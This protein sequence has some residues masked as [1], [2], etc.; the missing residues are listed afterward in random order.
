M[1]KFMAIILILAFA[2]VPAAVFADAMQFQTN[3]G[4]NQFLYRCGDAVCGAPGNMLSSNLTATA[5]LTPTSCGAVVGVGTDS[6]TFTLPTGPTA[7]QP[8][9]IIQ[10][11]N[12][13]T[14]GNNIIRIASNGSSVFAGTCFSGAAIAGT[15]ISSAVG[16]TLTNTKAT[17]KTGDTVTLVSAGTTTWLVTNC[18]GTW[19]S[20]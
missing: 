3:S 9:C 16:S 11:A 10:F 2:L 14:A 19:A 5:T 4:Q 18:T 13:G 15:I 1:K 20:N 12:T 8:P 17:A 6:L 7:G